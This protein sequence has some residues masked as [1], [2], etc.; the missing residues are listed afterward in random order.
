MFCGLQPLGVSLFLYVFALVFHVRF[1]I[2]VPEIIAAPLRATLLRS[3]AF[4]ELY[5]HPAPALETPPEFADA[6]FS[7]EIED[8]EKGIHFVPGDFAALAPLESELHAGEI[9]SRRI[10]DHNVD[11]PGIAFQPS[12]NLF[13]NVFA[14]LA[15]SVIPRF[16]LIFRY[17]QKLLEAFYKP[18]H[19]SLLECD[20]IPV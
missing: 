4:G 1:H 13:S 17:S 6:L 3:I 11:R 8:I 10:H 18:R 5:E 16:V 9:R 19:C 7:C 2:C 20:R 12:I 15:G 14:R